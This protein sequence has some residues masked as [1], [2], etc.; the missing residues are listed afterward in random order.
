MKLGSKPTHTGTRYPS[1]FDVPVR[2]RRHWR[3]GDLAD[4]KDFGVNVLELA[5]GVWSSQRH[6]H[7]K[8][9]E[10]IWILEGEVV[11]VMNEGEHILKA[12]EYAVFAAGEPNGHHLQNRTQSIARVLEVGSKRDGEDVATYPDIDLMMNEKSEFT[13]RDGRPY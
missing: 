1:P 8:E 13:H 5:P 12:G 4:L 7:S 10:L 2:A 9:E 3:I 11:L 6:W